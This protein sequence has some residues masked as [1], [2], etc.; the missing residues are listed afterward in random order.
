MLSPN[1]NTNMNSGIHGTIASAGSARAAPRSGR[2]SARWLQLGRLALPGQVW[3]MMAAM[4]ELILLR[5][6]ETEWRRRGCHTGRSDVPLTERGE[7]DAIALAP[8]LAKRQIVASFTSPAQR[9]R[10]TAGLAGLAGAE[11][12]PNL[13]EWDYGGYEGLT[14][15]QIRQQRPDWYLWRDGV[16]P[17]D[18]PGE[19]IEDVGRRADAVLAR[20]RPLLSG[21]DVAL[22]SHAHMLRV[23]TAR[24]LGL[25]PAGGRL[26]RLET[27]TL[28]VLG[29]EHGQDVMLSWNV[30][31]ASD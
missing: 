19:S 13:Q 1:R 6:G 16:I 4:G 3:A 23:L 10:C 9:A 31:P 15:A 27:G 28:S 21:G 14:T 24:W 5:H 22:V 18:H 7:A 30:S 11:V 26:F 25:E 20:V 8:A 2:S 17:G 12:D 29:D